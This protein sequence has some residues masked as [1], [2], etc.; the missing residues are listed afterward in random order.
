MLQE[1]ESGT[2]EHQGF[3]ESLWAYYNLLG[4]YNPPNQYNSGS[5]KAVPSWVNFGSGSGSGSDSGS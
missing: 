3:A 2:S 5:F 4:H 1:K